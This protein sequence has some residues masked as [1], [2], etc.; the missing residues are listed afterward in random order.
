[1][2]GY[3][4]EETSLVFSLVCSHCN[5]INMTNVKLSPRR[6]H[7]LFIYDGLSRGDSDPNEHNISYIYGIFIWL[8]AF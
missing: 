5:L 4:A 1:M 3:T 7:L 8:V 6:K 2:F